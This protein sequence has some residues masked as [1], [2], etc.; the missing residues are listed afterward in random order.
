MSFKLPVCLLVFFSIW[1]SLFASFISAQKTVNQ[2]Q[3]AANGL[4]FRLSEAARQAE[5]PQKRPPVSIENL[6]EAEAN[7]IFNRLPPLPAEKEE[8]D[9]FKMRADSLKPPK[10]GNIIPVKFPSDEKQKAPKTKPETSQNLEIRRYSPTGKT[11]LAVDLSITFS[12]PMIAVTS[13]TQA[14]ENVP[15]ELKP[16][17]K[18]RWRWL[19]TDTLIFDATERFPMATVFNATIP[20][21]TKSVT[22]A[23]L[24]K[25]FSWTFTMP[26][27]TVE[28]F[29]PQ[30]ENGEIF[31]EYAIMAAK[32]NQEIDEKDIF[33]KINVTANGKEMPIR[34]V[35]AEVTPN[36]DAYQR[37]GE[38]KPKHWLAFRTVELLPL[39]AQVVVSFEKG[40]PSAEGSLKSETEQV[41]TFKT[42]P[43]LKFVKSYCGYYDRQNYC[44]P[45]NDFRI[46]FNHSLFPAALE[47][48]QV[49]IE[50]EIENVRIVPQGNTLYIQGK[51]KPNTSYKVTVSGSI[52]DFYKQPLGSD[53]TTTFNVGVEQRQFF[54]LGGDFVTL[55]PFAK[56][57]FSI[58]SKNHASFKF[59][60]YSVTTDDYVSYRQVLR[61]YYNNRQIAPAVNFGRQILNKTVEVNAD[62]D[63]LTETRIDLSEALPNGF[64]HAILVAE[65]TERSGLYDYRDLPFVVW[66]QSTN[67]G[68]DA[69]LDY[70]KMTAYVSELKTGKPLPNAE[71][72]LHNDK[73][74]AL[75][76]VTDNTGV[77]EF[78]LTDASGRGFLLAKSGVDSAILREPDD[79]ANLVTSWRKQGPYEHLRWFVFD[80]RKMYRPGEEV[81][82]KGYLR[83]ITTGKFADIEELGGLRKNVSYLLRDS[84]YNEIARGTA[85]LNAFGA[86][87]FKI[88]LPENINLGYQRLE[89]WSSEQVSQYREYEHSFQVQEF[90]RPEFEV[91][92]NAETPAPYTVGTSA[93]FNAEAKYFTGGF[94]RNSAIKWAVSAA[95]TNYS[96]PGHESFTFGSFIPWWKRYDDDAERTNYY[97]SY[98]AQYISGTTDENGKHRI[99]L[100][101]LAAN[102]ARPYNLRAT[103]EIQD[104]NRQTIAD[105]KNFLVHPSEVYV[106]LKTAKTFVRQG[107]PLKV[108]TIA[109]DIDGKTV[110]GAPIEITAVLKDWQPYGNTWREVLIDTQNCQLTSAASA[111]SCSFNVKQGGR[112]TISATVLDA[113]ERPN[114]SELRV[115][116]AGGNTPPKRGVELEEA[117]LIPDKRNYAP[118]ETAEILVNAPFFLAEGVMTLERSGVVKTVRF[119][120]NEASTVLQIPIEERFLPNVHVKVDLLGVTDRTN[121]KGEIDKTLAKRPAF[122]SGEINLDVSTDSRKLNVAVEPLEKVT[123]PGKETKINVNVKD[124]SGNPVAET[125]V[126][127]V[128]VD[129]GVLSLTDYKIPNPLDIFYQ[130]IGAGV[131]HYHSRERV[132]L[133]NPNGDVS[134]KLIESL[135][136][137]GR[138]FNALKIDGG[139]L[140]DSDSRNVRAETKAVYKKWIKDDVAYIITEDEKSAI[141]I[142]KNFDALAIYSPSV[143]T[144]SSGKATVSVKLPDNLTRYR[145]TAVAVT[146]SKQF[147]LGESSLTARQDLMVR[148]S[149]PRF[150]NFG[151]RAELPV[152][153][154]NQSNNPL[155]VNVAVRGS[156]AR[157]LE[158]NGR[159]VTIPANDR[160]EIRF[161]VSVES[162]GVARFQI[163]AV[164]GNLADAAEFAF[165]VYTP[166][167]T[168]TFATYG[169]TDESGAIVQSI[170]PPDNVF[171]QFG[172]LE[173]T[174][175]STQLQELTDAFIYLQNY[176][177]ECSEQ[178]SSR[179][180]SVAALRD[181]LQAFQAKDLPTKEEIEA[182]MR[183][184]IER[185]RKLQ[186]GDGGF[187][188]WSATDESIPY[189]SAHVAHALARAKAK[190]YDVPNEMITKSLY[191]LK[192]IEAYFPK[193]YSEESRWAISAYA[194]Y[195][196]DL[197]G[198]KDAAKAKKLISDVGLEKL[199][200]ESIGWLLSVLA[201]DK[202]SSE[203]IE[204]IRQNLLNRVTE[205]AAAAH[206]VTKYRDGEY[207]LLASDRRADG[208]ILEAFLKSEPNNQI[209][210]KIVRGLLAARTKGRWSNTQENAI[211]LLALDKYFQTYEKVTPNFVAKIWLGQTFAGEQKFA[212]RSADSN[213]ISVPMAY[214]QQSGAKQ[215]L[216]MDKQ[217]AGRLYYRIGMKYAPKN[218]NLQAADYG[219][220]ISRSYEAMDNPADV[221][222]NGDG[223]WTI[224]SGARV[225]VR[226]QMVAP[227]VRYHVALV[228]NL[229]AGLE[230]VNPNLAVSG[231]MNIYDSQ[232]M[233]RRSYWFQHQ[234]FRDNRAEAF[235]MMLSEG[236]WNYSYIALATTP[237][238]FIVPPAKAEEMYTPET[239]G[240]SKTSF[241][242][243]D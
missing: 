147:G 122:A 66:I 187:S 24:T 73:Y 44:E 55:D 85:P 141:N 86:F 158:G 133:G 168:E 201:D 102:P 192:N 135:P 40:L 18:G 162:S 63:I 170:A 174:T 123:E 173:I 101:F 138:S 202:N 160:A 58:Y 83:K 27:P 42:L 215:N 238:N 212:G 186:H 19:G 172:G 48:G 49:K 153:L 52:K 65:P 114:T 91:N 59:R 231:N 21:G 120:M 144:D 96:P 127:L 214:L 89:F 20:K 116:A 176:S 145:I 210:P 111:V 39:D 200:A 225:R 232:E 161:P 117:E 67:I 95:R 198:D 182:K 159:R 78:T 61:D 223:S 31:P 62:A 163:G 128:A 77:A 105:T 121:D 230:I 106:G 43:P 68:I 236:V 229:P 76:S 224:K 54:S 218:L 149:A 243:I 84:R 164:S 190:G 97:Y 46:E 134:A 47:P 33:S 5:K 193:E 220:A 228:D 150:M 104:V 124:F 30:N 191:Y 25:D 118:G 189:L 209:I 15:V 227:S 81:S 171:P 203:Q 50:P 22:G 100:D 14:S 166:A 94:L 16:E 72:S 188:F 103:A 233:R 241:V 3:I 156:N 98:P 195:V 143:R 136:V 207:V 35:T 183:S 211:V 216:T 71:I 185:L 199:S 142:R 88:K 240:R 36:Y 79:Y 38:V 154:Q 155:T 148:P 87:D 41:F 37:L 6:S 137:E 108:E 177:F 45:S 80:D 129:E 56:P 115:W 74:N 82:V 11:P 9:G 226:I 237:G 60:L 1:T 131:T 112:F 235:T 239:F 179:V 90:R 17:V 109:A 12:Q 75:N 222:Q 13:Q 165:P 140:S 197:L 8:T 221:K 57:V 29:A 184:D 53:L 178:I 217:G 110:A 204:A 180:L 206:F 219:F 28:K 4:Q 194:L 26:P 69:L 10:S 119:T 234:N 51:K 208:V 32:F 175:S 146:K 130:Q 70:E 205:T 196:R 169:T 167:T 157:L 213:L 139:D 64:G 242:R 107:E 125:E 92:I 113:K 7:E 132:I 126:A 151:D 2:P 93:V 23:A 34:L 181:V 99:N 152:V